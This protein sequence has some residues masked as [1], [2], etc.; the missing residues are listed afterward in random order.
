M[1][2][3]LFDWCRNLSS[4]S[5][6]RQYSDRRLRAGQ[7]EFSAFDRTQRPTRYLVERV[8]LVVDPPDIRS[9][10]LAPRNPLPYW[11][12]L[13]A[14]KTLHVGSE[15]LRDA[16]GS[17][18]RIWLGPKRLVPPMVMVTSPQGARDVL[19]RSGALSDRGTL[20]LLKDLRRAI[21]ESVLNLPHDTWLPRRRTL[22]PIFTKQR[23][24]GFAGH[25]SEAANH[26]LL[27]WPDGAEVDLNAASHALVL[28]VVGHSVFGLDLQDKADVITT[29]VTLAAKWAADRSARPVRAPHWLPTPARRR[30]RGAYDAMYKIA[31][32]MLAAC[33][34]D[35]SRE[36]PLIRAL[37]DAT[38]PN[39]GESLSDQQI[40]D[41]MVYFMI[42]GEDT[43]S[44]VL[45]YA[46]WALGQHSQLQDRVA[47]E[48]AEL[49]DR[50]LTP[51]DVPRL[52]YTIQVLQ[53]AMRLCPP[54]PTVAR[55][56]MQD[57]EVDGYRVQAGTYCLVGVYA[58]HRDPA[59]WDDPLA[60]DPDRFAPKKS[61]G[62]DRWQY[63]PFGGGGRSCL[64][65][66]FAMLEASL[67]LATIIREAEIHSLDGDFP[68]AIPLP[69]VPA[70]PIRAR[71]NQRRPS[72]EVCTTTLSDSSA[73]SSAS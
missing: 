34:A 4:L 64:G 51:A 48:A 11:Q 24:A 58:M 41:E 14:L 49:G 35:P 56:A 2:P 17:V 62:R 70:G 40:C 19:G 55:R 54:G 6:Y 33:R 46:L 26:I 21:G 71:V 68:V 3:T 66:H 57:I 37:I 22:Q 10:P 60:F 47:A 20:P 69:I 18:T 52:G 36:A 50:P 44:T 59:L 67:A 15:A 25:M 1:R 53:E 32:D 29:G 30:A 27:G 23:V 16:G 65:D 31:A 7:M 45:T 43:T 28:R 61:K 38:D 73:S 42:L 72:Q 39:T 13:K 63:L 8:V 5:P 12:Q 9:L